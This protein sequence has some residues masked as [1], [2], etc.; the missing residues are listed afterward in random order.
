M[1]GYDVI[2]VGCEC[3]QPGRVRRQ[4]FPA[5]GAGVLLDWTLFGLV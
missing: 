2:L 4:G 1:V 3:A 5:S